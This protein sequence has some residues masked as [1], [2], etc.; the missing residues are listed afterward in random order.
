[1]RRPSATSRR[2]TSKPSRSGIITSSR[3]MS[4]RKRSTARS[5]SGPVG[6]P[7]DLEAFVAQAH[8]QQLSDGV[9]VVGDEHSGMARILRRQAG[10]WPGGALGSPAALP[11]RGWWPRP[12]RTGRRWAGQP[13]VVDCDAGAAPPSPPEGGPV[14]RSRLSLPACSLSMVGVPADGSVLKVTASPTLEVR[15][16]GLAVLVDVA[17]AGH[18]VGGGGRRR[19]D[20]HA[21][22]R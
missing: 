17:G 18:C 12:G 20:R 16:V 2:Q 1:M 13:A 3:I 22:W 19:V 6:A 11:G 9:F 7:L 15:Q 14:G 4:G 8:R 5:A 21:A 10:G